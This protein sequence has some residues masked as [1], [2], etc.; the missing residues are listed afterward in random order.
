MQAPSAGLFC[1][2]SPTTLVTVLLSDYCTTLFFVLLY[3]T[4]CW[5]RPPVYRTLSKERILMWTKVHFLISVFAFAEQILLTVFLDG[6]TPTFWMTD[7][8][9][10]STNIRKTTGEP[11]TDRYRSISNQQQKA[12]QSW[13]VNT[14]VKEVYNTCLASPNTSF[15]LF[16]P[17]MPCQLPHSSGS[18]PSKYLRLCFTVFSLSFLKAYV[19]KCPCTYGNV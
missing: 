8:K 1:Y 6:Q 3:S 4:L 5:L 15:F 13:E 17:W 7:P 11:I 19:L 14:L 2:H 9:H 12:N 10:M 18:C 16:F